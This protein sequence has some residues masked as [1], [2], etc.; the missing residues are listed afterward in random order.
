VWVGDTVKN[1][2][3]H[4]TSTDAI[5]KGGTAASAAVSG[6]TLFYTA[7]AHSAVD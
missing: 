5:A 6:C 7:G 4:K 3:M 1:I 2:E